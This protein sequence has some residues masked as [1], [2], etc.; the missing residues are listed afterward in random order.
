[1]IQTAIDGVYLF[2]EDHIASFSHLYKFYDLE[3]KAIM[4]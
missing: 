2:L 4:W 1:M 3:S